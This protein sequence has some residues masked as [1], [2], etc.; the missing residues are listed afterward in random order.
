M[1]GGRGG[2]AEGMMEMVGEKKW[3]MMRK[4]RMMGYDW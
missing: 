2:K 4:K 3:R 1:N